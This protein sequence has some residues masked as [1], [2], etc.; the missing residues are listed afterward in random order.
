MLLYIL[1]SNRLCISFLTI[2]FNGFICGLIKQILR[3]QL[4][5]PIWCLGGV[6][7]YSGCLPGLGRYGR[8]EFDRYLLLQ[9]NDLTVA[10]RREV[11]FL[12]DYFHKIDHFE[13]FELKSRC[14]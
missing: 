2:L 10:Q 5:C 6:P 12:A 4:P 11:I 3:S 8:Y 13:F 14:K 1:L 9:K 7:A